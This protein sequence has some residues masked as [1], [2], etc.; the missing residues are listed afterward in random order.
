MAPSTKGKKRVTFTVSAPVGSDVAVA[1]SF[2]DWQP[3]KKLIDKDGVGVY[4]GAVMLGK[5]AHQYKFVI[6]GDWFVDPVNPN[7]TVTEM[8]TMNSVLEVA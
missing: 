6:D 3:K 5:G 7:F 8:G 1:G 2:S 4:T